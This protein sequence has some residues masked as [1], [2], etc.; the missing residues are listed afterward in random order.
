MLPF[1]TAALWVLA[2]DAPRPAVVDFRRDVYPILK[3]ACFDCHQ[4][5]R[6]SS[7]IRLDL[8]GDI[9]GETTGKPLAVAGKGGDS[10]LFHL[11][12]GTIP[13]KRM[14]KTGPPLSAAQIQVLRTWI[15]EGL[16]WDDEL[17]PPDTVAGVPAGQAAGGPEGAS[18]GL[19]QEPDRQLH[20]REA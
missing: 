14:P 7:G 6:A 13:G 10:R 15:D 20:S 18:G 4:G 9:L 16:A 5:R 1:A 19:G 3:T 8:R 11:I 2:A 12:A 17:L